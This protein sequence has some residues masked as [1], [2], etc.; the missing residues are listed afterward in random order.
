VSLTLGIGELQRE[1]ERLRAGGVPLQAVRQR[2]FD[3]RRQVDTGWVEDRLWT[4]Y[5]GQ[6]PKW[7]RIYRADGGRRE[8][9]AALRSNRGLVSRLNELVRVPDA[10]AAVRKLLTDPAHLGRL[11]GRHPRRP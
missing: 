8:F 10:V 1:V 3:G 11:R 2:L 9:A 7:E 5:V 4:A 6:T